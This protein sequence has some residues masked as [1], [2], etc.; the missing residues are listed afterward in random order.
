MFN[1]PGYIIVS[2]QRY[3]CHHT[4]GHGVMN[5]T[6][7]IMNSCNPAFI[8]MGQ[9]LGAQ[10]FYRYFESFGFT[11]KTGVDIPGESGSVYHHEDKMGPTELASSS[12]GQ[13]FSI[14]PMQILTACCAVIN[15]GYLVQPHVVSQILDEDGNVIKTVDTTTKRQV[16]SEETSILMRGLAEKV[17][18]G[19]SGRNAYVPGFRIGGKTGT[20]QKVS[21]M[22][23]TGETGLYVSSFLGIA[24]MDNPEIAILLILDEPMGEAYYG[25]TIVAPVVGNI[26]SEVLPYLGYEPQ[27]TAQELANMAIKVPDVET[28]DVQTASAIVKNAGL[29]V[30]VVGNGKTVLNQIPDPSMSVYKNGTIILYTEEETEIEKV[31]VPNFIGLTAAGVNEL[32]IKNGINVQFTGAS[33]SVSGVTAYKQSISAG[34]EVEK[35]TIVSVSFMDGSLAD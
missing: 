29:N 18:D 34:T 28:K 5:L 25:S 2:G 22:L 21:K 30:T 17:V 11:Q 33:T 19:G 9:L 1:C 23:E 12:F 35:G 31:K 8:T 32:A 14:T 16:I 13:T 10:K 26:M 3:R 4:A 24:P 20:S 15:G 27:Y 6:A 7:S